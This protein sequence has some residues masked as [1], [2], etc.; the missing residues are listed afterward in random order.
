[1]QKVITAEQMREIDN[2]TTERFNIPSLLLME[3][4]AAASAKAIAE[5]FG[6]RVAGKSVLVLCGKGN[7]GGDG[8]ALARQLFNQGAEVDVVLLGSVEETKD[9]ARTNFEILQSLLNN[10]TTLNEEGSYEFLN[11]TALKDYEGSLWFTECLTKKDWNKLTKE[12][13]KDEPDILVDALFGTGLTRPL[14]GIY[15]DVLTFISFHTMGYTPRHTFVVSLDVPSGIQ[16]N[17]SNKIDSAVQANLTITF[18]AP[19][20]ANVLPPASHYNGKLV[21]A[22]IGSPAELIYQAES[23]LFLTEPGDVNWWLYPT[24]YV[25]G[26]YKNSHGHALVIAGSRGMSG[27]AVLCGNA[28]MRAGAGLVT[29]ATSKSAQADVA[30]RTMPEVMTAIL[31]ETSIGAVSFSAKEHFEKLLEKATVVAIGCGLNASQEET[32]RFVRYVVE[33]RKTPVVIDADGLNALS[34]WPSRLKGSNLFPLILTP[35]KGEFSRL[36]GKNAKD[37]LEDR[38]S[39]ASE[40]AVKHN[41][42]LVL[43]GER[44]L[45]ASPDGNVIVNPTGNAGLGTAGAG[46]TLTGI[47]TGFLAQSFALPESERPNALETVVAALYISGLA[48]DIAAREIGMRTM[49]ASDISHHLSAAIRELDPQG[50]R[51]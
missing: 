41:L 42:I 11:M 14:T 45:I 21:V 40:F 48:G 32:R 5:N 47:I 46:D 2:L 10:R 49:T 16:A 4:A 12:V 39:V 44:S 19:K 22:N 24:R 7:N 27:A 25:A 51:P 31:N 33:N 20:P 23:K 30:A 6:G 38:V 18:T 36:V 34:P 13:F 26:S 9:E 37:V 29:V 50:E 43:K 28:A 1:M 8:A 3:Q 17:V 15:E 35:H